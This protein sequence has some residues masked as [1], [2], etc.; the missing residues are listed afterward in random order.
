MTNQYLL[1]EKSISDIRIFGDRSVI[2]EVYKF[3]KN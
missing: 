2:Q 3:P 1:K